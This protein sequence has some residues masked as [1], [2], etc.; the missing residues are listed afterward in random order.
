M[1]LSVRL[2]GIISALCIFSVILIL[3]NGQKKLFPREKFENNEKQ[4]NASPNTNETSL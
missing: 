1:I 2:V 4:S 3:I